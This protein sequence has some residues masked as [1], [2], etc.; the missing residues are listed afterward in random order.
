[1]IAKDQSRT[2]RIALAGLG[3]VGEGVYR[4]LKKDADLISQRTSSK[5]RLVAVSARSKKEFLDPD[6]EFVADSRTLATRNDIDV[7][8]EVIGGVKVAKELCELA[9]KNH[10]IYITANKQLIAEHGTELVKLAGINGSYLAFEAAVAGSIPVIK[11][12]KEGFSANKI[13][14][15]SAILNGTCNYILSKMGEEGLGF[16]EALKTAQ[17]LGY[18]EADP[19]FDINGTDT[20]HKLA[21]LS[22]VAFGI[23]PEFKDIHV[24]GIEQ[25]SAQDIAL[26]KALGYK[27]KLLAVAKEVSPG[28]YVRAVYPALVKSKELLGQ[29]NDSFNAIAS[30]CSNAGFSFVSGRGAGALPTAS[31]VLADLVDV[32]NAR[33]SFTFGINNLAAAKT[34]NIKDRSGK[35]LLKFSLTKDSQVKNQISQ[36]KEAESF[37]IDGTTLGVITKVIKENEIQSVEEKILSAISAKPAGFLRVE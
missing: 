35:Y 23:N 20:G 17:E 9:L 33:Y 29:V 7:I 22:A 8:I 4:I 34:V 26:A 2:L 5:I 10:K 1:M 14:S 18:A 3:V 32:A 19:A 11:L 6:I 37:E 13:T 30:T 36:I 27:I 25:I 28:V 12:F 16:A 15:F 21:L 24:E 31:A